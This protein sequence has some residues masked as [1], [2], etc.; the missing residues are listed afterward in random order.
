ME[1]LPYYTLVP[2]E[3]AQYLEEILTV[4]TM[5]E[6]VFGEHRKSVPS[7]DDEVE[8]RHCIDFIVDQW[9]VAWDLTVVAPRVH[10]HYTFS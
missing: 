3:V 5:T 10:G 4:S 7:L 6:H 8:H 2:G 1:Q 9:L